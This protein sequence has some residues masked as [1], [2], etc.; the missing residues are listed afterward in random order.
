MVKEVPQP[1]KY[2]CEGCDKV[3]TK[4]GNAQRCE[5]KDLFTLLTNK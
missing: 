5:A 3:Y 4:F 2:Q 1:S